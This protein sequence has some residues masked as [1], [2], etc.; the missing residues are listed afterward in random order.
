MFVFVGLLIVFAGVFGGYIAA[1]GS[2]V[3]ILHSLPFEFAMIGGAAIGAFLIGNPT[4]VMKHTLH[5]FKVAVK[6]THWKKEDYRDL[7]LLLFTLCKLMKTKGM[8]AIEQHIERPEES[9]IF[10]QYPHILKDPFAIK[11]ICDY[12]RMLTMDLTDAMTLDDALEKEIDRY[13]S[14]EMHG[15]HTLQNMADALPALGIVA[16]VLGV[17]KTMSS[18]NEP[19]EILGKMIGGA[20]VG[21]FLGVF[22]SY[23][24]V[25]PF[26]TKVGQTV[27]ED[28]QFYRVIKEILVAHLKGNAV[29]ISIEI[30][31]G[32]IPG[33]LQPTFIEIEEA[34]NNLPSPGGAAA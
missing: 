3:V 34:M 12:L 23:A 11:L 17:I 30:G 33:H 28:M 2:M 16:A 18:I 14:E 5:G 27:M 25:A 4:H 22:L 1:G 29:Q 13:Q 6:G 24:V 20:L 19:P 7:L 26:G 32:N 10:R 9:E 31:R 8:V 15:P 21:T